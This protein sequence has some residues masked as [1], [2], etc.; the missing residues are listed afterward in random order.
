[1]QVVL[2][3]GGN[4]DDYNVEVKGIGEKMMFL[5]EMFFLLSKFTIKVTY[6]MVITL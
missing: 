5:E 3:S 6:A 2:L 1:V 4:N